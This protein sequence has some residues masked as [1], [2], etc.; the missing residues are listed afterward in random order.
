MPRIRSLKPEFFD[1]EE[2]AKLSF[3]ARLCF[4]GLWVWA[5][6]RGV[7]EDRP[8]RL[9]ARIFPFDDVDMNALL[10]ELVDGKFI[11]RYA[12]GE[13]ACIHIRTFEKHQKPHPKEPVSDLPHL[14]DAGSTMTSRGKTR[15]AVKRN[16][17]SGGLLSLGT[18][19]GS[20]SSS[21]GLGSSEALT[22]TEPPPPPPELDEPTVLR[23]P[24]VG[25]ESSWALAAS[26]LATW[27]SQFPDLDVAAQCQ[28]ALAWVLAKP[29]RRKTAK[30]MPAFLVGW[31]GRS[32]DR[33]RPVASGPLTR[34]ERA[35]Q[36]TREG[37]ATFLARRE[38]LE[39]I[40]VGGGPRDGEVGVGPSGVVRRNHVG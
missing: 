20:G 12:N 15:L 34:G 16:G 23:F 3:A 28:H 33:P 7:L 36:V 25:G 21:F 32:N 39:V 27:S 9:K 14:S 40:D 37:L 8:A 22:R 35:E 30:G 26:Q 4:Q 31:L 1:D 10:R 18:G 24:T 17:Q 6:K 2:V 38:A 5:D 11:V 29:N 13:H 19:S